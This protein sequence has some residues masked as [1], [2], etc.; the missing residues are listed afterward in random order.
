MTG[1]VNVEHCNIY[2]LSSCLGTPPLVGLD[3]PDGAT[4][5]SGRSSGAANR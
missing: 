3:K 4:Q 5:I 2:Y 1:Y